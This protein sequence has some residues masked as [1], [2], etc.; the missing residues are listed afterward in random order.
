MASVRCCA[1]TTFTCAPDPYDSVCPP[2]AQTLREARDICESAGYRLCSYEELR[3]STCCSTGCG[4]DYEFI[5]SGDACLMPPR[6]P[7]LPPAPP[8]P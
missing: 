7:P 2:A 8:M 6:Q 5:W 1:D 3:A 4:F